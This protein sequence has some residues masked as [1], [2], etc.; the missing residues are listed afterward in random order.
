MVSINPNIP[1]TLLR[2]SDDIWCVFISTDTA[3]NNAF[4]N[5]WLAKVN[6][7]EDSLFT[8]FVQNVAKI[9]K[10]F[11]FLMAINLINQRTGLKFR[12]FKI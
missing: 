10:Y 6:Q 1:E 2:F 7:H 5:I 9:R 4:L 8:A 12:K 3:E 11:V